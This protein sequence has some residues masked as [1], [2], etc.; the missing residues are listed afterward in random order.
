MATAGIQFKIMPE[1][2]EVDLENLKKEIKTKIE[3]FN[4]GVF[5]KA[6]EKPIAFGLKA[7][8][9]TIALSEDEEVDKVENAIKEIKGISSIELIDYRRAIG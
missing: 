7:L 3:S 9:I 2:L 5:N 6:E 4:S 8:I 1:N